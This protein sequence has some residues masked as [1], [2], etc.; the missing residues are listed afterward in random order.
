MDK[1]I[2]RLAV[3]HKK[4]FI[5]FSW[6]FY[7][8]DDIDFLQFFEQIYFFIWKYMKTTTQNAMKKIYKICVCFC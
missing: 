8:K 1:Y 6:L 3:Y 2:Y 7:P 5:V 4:F